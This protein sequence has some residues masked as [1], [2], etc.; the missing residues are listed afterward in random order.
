MLS[1]KDK[2]RISN[3]NKVICT[4][5]EDYSVWFDV[6]GPILDW[7]EIKFTNLI[8]NAKILIKNIPVTK[9]RFCNMQSKHNE[10]LHQV[11]KKILKIEQK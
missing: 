11:K 9:L 7:K 3:W 10:F 5:I 6:G 2:T 1:G 8:Q 4:L